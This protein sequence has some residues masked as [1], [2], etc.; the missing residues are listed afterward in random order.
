VSLAALTGDDW[1][2]IL[3]YGGLGLLLARTIPGLFRGRLLAGFAALGLWV[4][5]L[6]VALVG[7]AYRTE[8]G[9]IGTRVLAVVFP[10]TAVPTG[11]REVTVF[12]QFD[13]Q[14]SVVASA[15]AVRL[16]FVLDT[17]AST[18]VLRAED[19]V[20]LGL[21]VRR[22]TYDI[23]VATANG[24]ALTAAVTLPMLG[25]GSIVERDVDALVARPGALHENLLGMDFLNRLGSVTF[26]KDR[27]VLRGP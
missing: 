13:G 19:A 11:P 5:V 15:G 3:L 1:S 14:F 2:S 10:G 24:H 12:R 27:L 7:Y 9:G 8:L 23:P 17:G 26:A 4:A 22:L 20:L 16:P 18:V 21:P 25:I 6:S